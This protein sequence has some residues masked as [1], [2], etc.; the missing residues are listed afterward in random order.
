MLIWNYEQPNV[1]EYRYEDIVTDP[2]RFARQIFQSLRDRGALR[3]DVPF[4]E[5][6]DEVVR[7]HRF[8]KK[9]QG[10]R[11]GEEDVK[12]HFC[13][14]FVGD[15]RN[16]FERDHALESLGYAAWDDWHEGG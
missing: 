11:P 4:R 1:E 7:E 16:D 14:G 12:H 5:A 13:K 3:S 8:E 9:L 15:W 6:L 2:D 10:R